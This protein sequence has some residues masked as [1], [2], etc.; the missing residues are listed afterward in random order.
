[1]HYSEQHPGVGVG[2]L[3]VNKHRTHVLLGKRKG[4]H[5]AGQWSFPGG[6]LEY[7]EFLEDCA[8]R[9][10]KEETGLTIHK[11]DLQFLRAEESFVYMPKHVI[12]FGY[13]VVLKHDAVPQIMEPD[14]CE[15]WIWHDLDKLPS[16]MGDLA[17]KLIKHYDMQV[18]V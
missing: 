10:T 9:E 12:N 6:W 3:I 16:P 5:G 13:Y 8:V 11:S 17:D 18:V 1:M 4:S 14:K 15:G 2:I 7:G